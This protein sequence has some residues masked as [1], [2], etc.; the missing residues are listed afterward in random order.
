[1]W[2]I[3]VISTSGSFVEIKTQYVDIIFF[4]KGNIATF[5]TFNFYVGK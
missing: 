3:D 2:S 1:M 4:F 5:H